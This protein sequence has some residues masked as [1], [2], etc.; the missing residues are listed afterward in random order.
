MFTGIVEKTAQVLSIAEKNNGIR[1]TID[2]CWPDIQ[3]G[4][5]ICVN[6]ACLTALSSDTHALFD[7]SPETL[8]KTCFRRL[9]QGDWV[10]LERAMPANG[11]FSGHYVTG[12]VDTCA[13]LVNSHMLGDYHVM[14]FS[15]FVDKHASQYLLPKGSIAI[16]GVSL[17]I[18]K[19]EGDFIEVMI[20]PHTLK[21]TNL[22]SLHVGDSV[23]IE[24]DYFARLIAHQVRLIEQ[25]V[26]SV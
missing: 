13:T 8:D 5:S 12:H 15:Q 3:P 24:F 19:A 14:A 6:G 11:R 26:I 4:E 2:T 22:S 21:Y 7:L 17:T 9:K 18:N 1:L 23:N 10:N 20:I 16:N 25:E